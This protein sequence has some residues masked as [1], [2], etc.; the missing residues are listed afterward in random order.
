MFK[1]SADP[2]PLY[3]Q[4]GAG[5]RPESCLSDQTRGKDAVDAA[6]HLANDVQAGG[7]F[8]PSVRTRF[9]PSVH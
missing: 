4:H 7:G 5:V 1:L 8:L 3:Q 6:K 9:M 2:L